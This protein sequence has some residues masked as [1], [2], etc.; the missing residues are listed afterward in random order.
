MSRQNII[1][2]FETRKL[3][4]PP[5]FYNLQINVKVETGRKVWKYPLDFLRICEISE[6]FVFIHR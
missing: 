3:W 1:I 5:Y 6:M 4:V 2:P